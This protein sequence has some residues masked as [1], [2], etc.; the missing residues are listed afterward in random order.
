[1]LNIAGAETQHPMHIS[2][3]P[4]RSHTDD[5]KHSNKQTRNMGKGGWKDR[6]RA[7]TPPRAARESPYH[8]KRDIARHVTLDYAS[9]LRLITLDCVS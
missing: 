5:N 2:C 7:G 1:M 9:L 3:A 4:A 6:E 8:T